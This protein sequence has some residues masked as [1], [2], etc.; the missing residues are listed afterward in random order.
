[1]FVCVYIFLDKITFWCAIQCEH[2]LSVYVSGL[3]SCPCYL[4][5][6]Q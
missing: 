4:F 1:M 5:A 2:I 6:N 3:L